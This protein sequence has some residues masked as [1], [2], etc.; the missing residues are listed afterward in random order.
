MP[1]TI[2]ETGNEYGLLRV[3]WKT[4]RR[5][6]GNIM[7]HCECVCGNTRDVLGRKLRSGKATCCGCYSRRRRKGYSGRYALDMCD[8]DI[9]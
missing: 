8:D 1:N 6:A 5:Q 2:D 4:P 9:L 7:W 3:L